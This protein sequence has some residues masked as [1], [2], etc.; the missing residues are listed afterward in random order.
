MKMTKFVQCRVID[1]K[2]PERAD[3]PRRAI[4]VATVVRR[5]QSKNSGIPK[6]V[7]DLYLQ[8][9]PAASELNGVA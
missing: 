3:R 6:F 4:Q 7:A 1:S 8:L 9:D 5:K 2:M